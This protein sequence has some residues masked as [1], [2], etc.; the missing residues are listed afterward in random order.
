MVRVSWSSIFLNIPFGKFSRVHGAWLGESLY[1]CRMGFC[2]E[3]KKNN[4][5]IIIN[6]K[7]HIAWRREDNIRGHWSGVR[8]GTSA[9]EKAFFS[10]PVRYSLHVVSVVGTWRHGATTASFINRRNIIK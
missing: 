3:Q 6:N 8:A 5:T 9:R 1:P 7:R 2:G 4:T 10:E